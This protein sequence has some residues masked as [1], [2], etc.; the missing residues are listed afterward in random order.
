MAE[1]KFDIEIFEGK[2]GELKKKGDEII[3]PELEKEG[4]CAWMY[5]GD[6]TQSFRQG[7][8]FKYP[9]EAGKICPWLLDS[10]SG[11]YHVLRLGGTLPWDYAGTV[12]EKK[13]NQ[14]GV[15]TEYIRCVDPTDSGIVIKFTRT[16]IK[17]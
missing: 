9:E 5:R 4:I 7:Q 14:N 6:G 8:K 16:E 17:K 13:I 10:I 12:Y 1:Y 15:T 2:G 11:I 3:Y